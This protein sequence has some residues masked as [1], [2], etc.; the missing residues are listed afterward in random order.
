MNNFFQ[1]LLSSSSD[2]SHKRFIAIG[3]FFALVLLSLLN[4]IW[5]LKVDDAFIY[6][7][8]GL[9]GLQSTLSIFE[10][11]SYENKEN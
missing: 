1:K 10:K 8:A 4:Q 3:G 7:F 11:K 2:A 6:V 5:G 9:A